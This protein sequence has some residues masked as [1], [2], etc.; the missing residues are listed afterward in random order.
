MNC[1]PPPH[2][3][4]PLELTAESAGYGAGSDSPNVMLAYLKHIWISGQRQE[5][6]AR[7]GGKGVGGRGRRHMQGRGGGV[8]EKWEGG[9]E[10]GGER[11]GEEEGGRMLHVMVWSVRKSRGLMDPGQ[12]IPTDSNRTP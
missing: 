5:A 10:R 11:E 3:Y 2:R 12:A 7:C 1:P 6:Y 8:D 4:N 9:R